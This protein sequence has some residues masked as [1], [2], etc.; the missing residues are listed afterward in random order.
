MD[1]QIA[2]KCPARSGCRQ[3]EI[4]CNTGCPWFIEIRYQVELSGLPRRH[5][6]FTVD[7]LPVDFE[8]L[9]LWRKYTDDNLLNRV[10]TGKG[11]YLYGSTGNGKTTAATAIAMTYIVRQS[12][13]WI[14][15]GAKSTQLGFFRCSAGIDR[16]YET[17]I[18]AP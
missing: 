1:T 10:N 16:G 12:L 11:L 15:L 13:R 17:G 18:Y 7:N 9:T 14:R 6:K 5:A 3:H 2:A 8:H 4:M